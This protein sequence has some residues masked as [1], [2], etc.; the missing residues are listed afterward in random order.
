MTLLEKIRVVKNFIIG[1]AVSLLL[2][3]K[4]YLKNEYFEHWYSEG[5]EWA[6]HD[7][8]GR[9]HYDHNRRVPWPVFPNAFVPHPENIVFDSSS[10][11]VFHTSGVYFQA[12]NA[13]IIIGKKCWIAQNVGLITANHDVCNPEKHLTGKD[14]VLGDYCW[15]GMNAI[16][17]PGVHLGDHTVVGAGSVV[18][19]SFPQGYCI[20]AGNP[21]KIIRN[22][23][24]NS[25]MQTKN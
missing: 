7:F 22:I 18:T 15:I 13:K 21:A 16:L 11:N 3:E 9:K 8:W 25:E 2:Y 19:K 20:I 24:L 17:L 23:D 14:I 12:L 5:W 10:L 4:K 1:K 6:V